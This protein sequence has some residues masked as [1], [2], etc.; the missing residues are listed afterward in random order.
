MMQF[1][2]YISELRPTLIYGYFQKI[3]AR[4][5]EGFYGGHVIKAQDSR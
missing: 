4:H 5:F 1:Q 2:L 3:A